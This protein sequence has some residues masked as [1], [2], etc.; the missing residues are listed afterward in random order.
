MH[1]PF[2]KFLL[3][4]RLRLR[5]TATGLRLQ[6]QSLKIKTEN[7]DGLSPPA[8]NP[9]T[10]LRRSPVVP[11]MQAAEAARVATAAAAKE[12]T[13]AEWCPP[14]AEA[15]SLVRLG[16]PGETPLKTWRT[17]GNPSQGLF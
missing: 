7:V 12:A 11:S 15:S 1:I 16:V 13:A 9:R 6:L 2:K 17:R 3:C 10:T 4:C 5:F 14:T 8:N